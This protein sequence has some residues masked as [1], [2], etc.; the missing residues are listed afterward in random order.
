MTDLERAIWLLM[1]TDDYKIIEQTADS[2]TLIYVHNDPPHPHIVI[3]VKQPGIR[4]HVRLYHPRIAVRGRDEDEL[5]R[6]HAGEHHRLGSSTH[7]HGPNAGPHARP[8][9]WRDGSG[10]V[11]IDRQ[12][13]VRARKTG[14]D[15]TVTTYW[16]VRHHMELQPGSLSTGP[17][18]VRHGD[19]C[20]TE[21]IVVRREHETDPRAGG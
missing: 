7:H 10:A 17:H 2:A 16:C 13:A 18:H 8:R 11:L 4:E 5:A 6:L 21:R 3:Q 14:P 9:G 12:A 20:D 15:E 19:R 1:S